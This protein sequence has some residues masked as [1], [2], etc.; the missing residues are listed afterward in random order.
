MAETGTHADALRV[1][2]TGAS[3]DGAAQASP[4]LSLGHCRSSAE[5]RALCYTVNNPL[6]TVRVDFVAGDNGE[7]NGI[8]SAEDADSLAWQAPGDDAG[9]AVE[10]ASGESKVLESDDPDKYIRVT[11]LTDEDLAGTATLALQ[12]SEHTLFDVVSSEERSAGVVDY[13]CLALRNES[14]EAMDL[15]LALEDA[16]SY[17][18]AYDGAVGGAAQDRTAQG[19]TVSPAGL[20]WV[21]ADSGSPLGIEN[22]GAGETAFVWIRRTVAADTAA[23]ANEAMALGIA[24][25]SGGELYSQVYRWRYGI[26]DDSLAGYLVFAGQDGSPD[27]SGEPDAFSATLPLV[28]E[29]L[30]AGHTYHLVTRARNAYGL[31]SQNTEATVIVI[32]GD[33]SEA[34]GK[35]SAPI[36]VAV[37]AGAGGSVVVQAHY[38][39]LGDGDNGADYFAIFLRSNGSDPDP[40]NDIPTLVEVEPADGLAK[41]DWA[42][43]GLGDALDARVVVLMLRMAGETEIYSER[44][45]DGSDVYECETETDGPAAPVLACGAPCAEAETIWQHDAG[46]RIDWIGIPGVLRFYIGGVLVAAIGSGCRLLLKGAIREQSFV[47]DVAQE[48]ADSEDG[49]IEYAGESIWFATGVTGNKV[50]VAELQADGDLRVSRLR[51]SKSYPMDIAPPQVNPIAWNAAAGSLDFAPRGAALAMR[52]IEQES[53]GIH[54]AY[55]YLREVRENAL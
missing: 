28:L 47:A 5:L 19:D 55:L 29:S 13:R 2:L 31:V 32:A 8:L 3:E 9:A 6:P 20:T 37:S 44:P 34:A 24:F 26:A 33:G 49:S 40:G 39:Y 42:S 7:G 11:R 18:L 27:L 14:D 25:E 12:E 23:S 50:R 36:D 46:T 53:G 45:G 17:A 1:Y 54:N 16:A 38:L 48:P 41:L 30:A 4:A 51:E 15:A 35:P 21:A 22:L 10:I 52:M 43:D